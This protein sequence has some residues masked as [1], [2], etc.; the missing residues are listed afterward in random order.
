MWGDK[1][2]S[3]NDEFWSALDELVEMEKKYFM[4][5]ERVGFSHW[6]TGQPMI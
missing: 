3:Y 2:N 1:V 5:T 4:N 6:T